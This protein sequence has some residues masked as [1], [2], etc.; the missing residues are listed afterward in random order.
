[1][2][3]ILILGATSGIARFVGYEY[4]REGATLYLA[5]RDKEELQR[6]AA[7]I[8]TK[9]GV[10]VHTGVFDVLAMNE[11]FTFFRNVLQ[12]LG[13]LDGLVLAVGYMGDQQQVKRDPAAA[14]RVID[15]NFTGPASIL[16]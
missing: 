14:Q 10:P 2:R 16:T 1:M 11:H 15:T 9:F 6:I 7:D 13:R 12:T 4:A 5:G 8:H 3:R